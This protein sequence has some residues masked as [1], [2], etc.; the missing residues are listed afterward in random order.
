MAEGFASG[1]QQGFGLVNSV[2][3][4]EADQ[5]YRQN[6]IDQRR[7]EAEAS[8]RLGMARNKLMQ[9]DNAANALYRS[10]MLEGQTAENLAAAE[11]RKQTREFQAEASERQDKI[12][13]AKVATENI[14]AN[15]ARDQSE[16]ALEQNRTQDRLAQQAL[17]SN[18]LL[19]TLE[20]I[21]AGN[22]YGDPAGVQAIMKRLSKSMFDTGVLTSEMLA[23]TSDQ[24]RQTLQD[25]SQGREI[26]QAAISNA[27]NIMLRS[28]NDIGIG[29]VI[30]ETYVNAPDFMKDG[31]GS[32]RVI[33]KEILD[34]QLQ[35]PVRDDKGNITDPG[36][37]SVSGMVLV[38]V[39]DGKGEF[40]YTAPATEGRG[41]ASPSGVNIN[42]DEL[43]Q[44][45]G[46]YMTMANAYRKHKPT[47]QRI[48]REAKYQDRNGRYDAAA[49]Q[50]KVEEIK[51]QHRK[52]VTDG[53][54]F[55]QESPIPGI[56]NDQLLQDDARFNEWAVNTALFPESN[57]P[58]ARSD[59]ENQMLAIRSSKPIRNLEAQPGVGSIDNRALQAVQPFLTRDRD[60]EVVVDKDFKKEFQ[61][62]MNNI[63]N[64][65]ANSS[66]TNTGQPAP[67][68]G[69]QARQR[70]VLPIFNP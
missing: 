29:N 14:K 66:S 3:D 20:S 15:Q 13:S 43:V 28:S 35:P 30:D 44:G 60:G 19:E 41:D 54:L 51:T 67:I 26:N 16:Y 64:R 6:A 48:Q 21:Q 47:I 2:F 40:Y 63:R 55:G 4:R 42:I 68:G 52:L 10:Q 53:N 56:T 69:L 58:S 46:G 24:V 50:N 32:Y 23:T 62:W 45:F 57:M 1:F 8:E 17:D 59:Y 36:G 5:E 9:D 61:Q 33:G 25:A 65:G 12:T 31:S 49:Y 27:L 11:A 70:S 38:T 7:A 37:N 34:L 22:F 18:E 39:S